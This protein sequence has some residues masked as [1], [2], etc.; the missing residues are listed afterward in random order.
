M[1]RENI[2]RPSESVFQR[3]QNNFCFLIYLLFLAAAVR[4]LLLREGKDRN[5][6]GMVR[7]M[8]CFSPS[9]RLSPV[10]SLLHDNSHEIIFLQSVK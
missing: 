8:L 7:F 6:G 1:L 5:W 9:F 3:K 2:L 4:I 10:T